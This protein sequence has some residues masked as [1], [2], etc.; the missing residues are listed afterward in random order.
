MMLP[1]I[2]QI[3]KVNAAVTALL[4][5]NPVR[6]FPFGEA[7]QDVARPYAVWQQVGGLPLNVLGQRPDMDGSIVQVDVYA[8][9][10]AQ[11]LQIVQALRDALEMHC[12]ITR[13]AG[14]ERD[15][16]TNDYRCGFD[17]EW[18]VGR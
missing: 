11:A 14:T 15:P 1:P 6:F 7:P 9:T 16:V 4:G 12:H 5:T 3:I 18:F 13:W 17:T 2:F 10:A 8:G